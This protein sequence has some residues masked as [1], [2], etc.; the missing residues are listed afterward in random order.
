[1]NSV[2]FFSRGRGYGHAI[3]DLDLAER[4][5]SM[6][7]DFRIEFASYSTGAEVIRRAGRNVWDLDL[8][9]S[10]SFLETLIRAQK[11]IQLLRPSAIIAH[12][13]F[14]A[15][16]AAEYFDVPSLFI[17]A[18]LPSGN[19]AIESLRY[20]ASILVI[21]EPGIF[22]EPSGL[23][24]KPFFSGPYY[25]KL[26]FTSKDRGKCR[27]ALSIRENTQVVLV[28]A[29]GWASED[30]APLESVIV[31]AFLK[32]S[33]PKQLF[34]F[35]G[36]DS[37]RLQE[38]LREYADMITV[39]EYSKTIEQFICA[40]D[41]VI[42]KGTRGITLDASMLAVPTISLSYGLNPMDDL[43]IANVKSNVALNARA[44]NEMTLYKNMSGILAG[45]S[46]LANDLKE[47]R[48]STLAAV[49]FVCSEVGRLLCKRPTGDLADEY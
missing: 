16:V 44:T 29:G 37:H 24:C 12:E 3:P 9:D 47:C 32:L 33:G 21:E 45:R 1:M 36:K 6:Q 49:D 17:S 2:L 25:R 13:E 35:A 48:H 39:F 26:A 5:E 15:L 10:N 7:S 22:P 40:S 23:R 18:W 27:E 46:K 31:N 11:L 38:Q 19:I 43:L 20:A 30:R 41:L 34:W 8:P 42:T 14:P 4:L 28:V